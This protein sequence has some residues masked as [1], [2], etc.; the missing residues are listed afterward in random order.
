MRCTTTI[1][2]VMRCSRDYGGRLKQ[3]FIIFFFKHTQI[4][5]AHKLCYIKQVNILS[6]ERLCNILW[7]KWKVEEIVHMCVCVCAVCGCMCIRTRSLLKAKFMLVPMR[8]RKRK[9]NKTNEMESARSDRTQLWD[10]CV[11]ACM[12]ACVCVYSSIWIYIPTKSPQSPSHVKMTKDNIYSSWSISWRSPE[13][14]RWPRKRKWCAFLMAPRL[15]HVRRLFITLFQSDCS[16]GITKWNE[17]KQNNKYT[18]INEINTSKNLTQQTNQ[19]N[20]MAIQY[21]IS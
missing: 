12:R 14:I 1:S 16:I 6:N 13:K 8:W 7:L 11:H 9:L 2:T 5:S 4:S 19:S 10:C 15:V 21:E 3:Q 17:M 18:R 20:S